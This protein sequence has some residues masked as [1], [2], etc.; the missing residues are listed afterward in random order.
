M[1]DDTDRS[2][3]F[4]VDDFNGDKKPAVSVNKTAAPM[5]ALLK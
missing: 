2:S 3:E 5:G 4:S 1:V